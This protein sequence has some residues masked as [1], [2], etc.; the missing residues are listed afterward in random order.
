MERKSCCIVTCLHPAVVALHPEERG[1]GD[2][3]VFTSVY[4]LGNVVLIR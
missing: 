3:A 1:Q 4:H 2:L